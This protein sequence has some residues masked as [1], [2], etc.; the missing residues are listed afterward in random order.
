MML[1]W[2]LMFS[3][4][5]IA[6]GVVALKFLLIETLNF[7]GW[8][9]LSDMALVISAGVFLIGFMLS[10]TLADYKESE[11]IPGEIASALESIE[12]TCLNLAEKV[13]YPKDTVLKYCQEI[14]ICIDN[15]FLK[16]ASDE[17]MFA[18]LQNF[19]NLLNDLDKQGATPPVLARVFNELASLRRTLIRTSVISRT[20]FLTTGYVLLEVLLVVTSAT[21]LIIKFKNLVAMSLVVFFITL[22]YVYMYRLIKDIDD[23]FE[24]VE[25]KENVTEVAL[26]PLHEY[27]ERLRKRM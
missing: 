4:M 27:I 12:E 26:F 7:D 6:L 15:W 1:K 3:S 21:M 11:R 18:S 19:N 14:A 25:G 8:V 16:K 5:P 9:E 24:Y 20:G 23:P 13:S 22:V 2:K 17:Q 10:G